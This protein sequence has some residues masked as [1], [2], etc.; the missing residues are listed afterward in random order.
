MQPGVKY[1]QCV[2]GK[3]LLMNLLQEDLFQ[4]TSLQ[5]WINPDL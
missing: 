3:L 1:A 5:P 2:S 4:A